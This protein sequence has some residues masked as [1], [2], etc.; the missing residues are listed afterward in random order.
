MVA[1]STRR[2]LWP[3]LPGSTPP[4]VQQPGIRPKQARARRKHVHSTA[5]AAANPHAPACARCAIGTNPKHMHTQQKHVHST[6]A[7]A[8]NPRAPA[9]ARCVIG[10]NPKH[11]HARQK[12]VVNSTAAAGRRSSQ[13]S[14]A[15][16]LCCAIG[17]NPNHAHARQTHV[18]HST[19]AKA[20]NPRAPTCA[21][22]AISTNP[23][24]RHP[25]LPRA[26]TQSSGIVAQW[27]LLSCSEAGQQGTASNTR[28]ARAR[29]L[30]QSSSSPQITPTITPRSPQSP[31]VPSSHPKSNHPKST[32]IRNSPSPSPSHKEQPRSSPSP[33][34]DPHPHIINHAS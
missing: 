4:H 14:Y 28:V 30:R 10:T 34:H 26:T 31:P 21:R 22:S 1:S 5:A 7:A 19:A 18:V 2:A 23:S 3:P 12:H 25:R 15:R 8:A 16:T 11:A 27:H 6:A 20:A 32:A 29:E 24:A 17:N 9:C 33:S 13:S